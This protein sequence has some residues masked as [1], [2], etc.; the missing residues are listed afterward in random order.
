MLD[1]FVPV[2]TGGMHPSAQPPAPFRFRRETPRRSAS[3]AAPRAGIG[4]FPQAV[5]ACLAVR[6]AT[7]RRSTVVTGPREST[8]T[9]ISG[10]A[11]SGTLKTVVHLPAA[12]S[13]SSP[14]A[15]ATTRSSSSDTTWP[16]RSL[17]RSVE[18]GPHT[19]ESHPGRTANNRTCAGRRSDDRTLGFRRV[20]AACSPVRRQLGSVLASE[21][22]IRCYPATARGS[23]VTE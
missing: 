9:R 10:P 4:S 14:S 5:E 23:S 6:M 16:R 3:S 22:K 19:P 20:R 8:G 15:G 13:G 1:G 11:G 18:D 12:P 17:P 2:P 21:A 7:R